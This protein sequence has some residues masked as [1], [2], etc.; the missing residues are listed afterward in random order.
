M[1][2]DPQTVHHNGLMFWLVSH[3]AKLSPLQ[4]GRQWTSLPADCCTNVHWGCRPNCCCIVSEGRL[5][6]YIRNCLRMQWEQKGPVL[7]DP[8]FLIDS[9]WDPTWL[10]S[11]DRTVGFTPHYIVQTILCQACSQNT[12]SSEYVDVV[13]WR[14]MPCSTWIE[15]QNTKCTAN[16]WSQAPLCVIKGSGCH[17]TMATKM[18]HIKGSLWKDF[19]LLTPRSP[20]VLPML[21]IFGVLLWNVPLVPALD[22]GK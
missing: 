1:W 22:T 3:R 9:W 8:H 11:D 5:I 21:V 10:R 19:T 14:Q 4:S 16:D 15:T 18:T 7:S 6:P 13:L 20:V 2:T 12:T 17:F